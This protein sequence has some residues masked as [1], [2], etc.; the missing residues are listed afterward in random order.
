MPLESASNS[1]TPTVGEQRCAA[2]LLAD[3]ESTGAKDCAEDRVRRERGV[4]D[5]ALI[6]LS[7]PVKRYTPTGD[8]TDLSLKHSQLVK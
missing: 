6:A 3:K 1:R 5:E 2:I 4:T 7:N 8:R